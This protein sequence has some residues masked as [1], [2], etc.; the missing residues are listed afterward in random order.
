MT[1]SKH[2]NRVRKNA[3]T[4]TPYYSRVNRTTKLKGNVQE[5]QTIQFYVAPVLTLTNGILATME[6]TP[7]IPD[8]SK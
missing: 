2:Y 5:L 4:S 1:T 6:V 3:K 8:V 7:V